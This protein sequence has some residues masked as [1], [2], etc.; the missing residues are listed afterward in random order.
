MLSILDIETS[1]QLNYRIKENYI[2]DNNTKQHTSNL[3]LNVL[4]I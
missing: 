2:F 3:S 1:M 4:G